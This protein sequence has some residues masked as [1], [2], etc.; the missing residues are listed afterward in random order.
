[1]GSTKLFTDV[2]VLTTG[3]QFKLYTCDIRMKDALF[4][5]W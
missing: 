5:K 4:L 1:M 2:L 3:K